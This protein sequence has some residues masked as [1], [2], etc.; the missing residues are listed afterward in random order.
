MSIVLA[1]M[2]PYFLPN[3][4]YFRLIGAAHKFVIL[5][6]VSISKRKW[7]KSNFFNLEG[8]RQ[9]VTVPL[10]KHSD[11]DLIKDVNVHPDF[12]YV[13]LMKRFE[14]SYKSSPRWK[15]YREEL[16]KC[17]Q[18]GRSISELNECLI[19]K[20]VRLQN[21]Q[22]EILKASELGVAKPATKSERLIQLCHAVGADTYINNESGIWQYDSDEFYRA[23]I[24]LSSFKQDVGPLTNVSYLD[25]L[26]NQ[27][28]AE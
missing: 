2:Q 9:L 27:G 10:S 23:G 26:L 25:V 13:K 17:F 16:E 11:Q 5:D 14:Q 19:R 12:D 6:N 20:I 22:T 18:M 7:I 28:I 24:K 3:Q 1:V 21:Y 15:H 4:N 8:R